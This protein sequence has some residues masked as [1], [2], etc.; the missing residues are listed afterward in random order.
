MKHFLVELSEDAANFLLLNLNVSRP[1][2]HWR[3]KPKIGISFVLG[4]KVP[5]KDLNADFFFNF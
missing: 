3:K 2:I 4:T 1:M 5:T